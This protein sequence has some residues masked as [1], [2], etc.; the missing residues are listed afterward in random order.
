MYNREIID[1]P[2]KPVSSPMAAKIKSVLGS[3]KN[4]YCAWEPL[5][6]PLPKNPPEPIA[7]C[8][9]FLFQ[10]SPSSSFSAE[11]KLIILSF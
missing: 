5:P 2:T 1:N 8:A 9:W 3:G 6:I 7:I 11:I 10:S 4:P